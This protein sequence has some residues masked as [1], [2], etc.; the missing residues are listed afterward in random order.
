MKMNIKPLLLLSAVIACFSIKAAE[1][2]K[3]F[4]SINP[5]GGITWTND[6]HVHADHV[7]MAG[8]KMAVVLHYG[9]NGTGR[10]TCERHLVFPMLRT[11]PNDT[12][13]S[14]IRYINWDPLESVL[15]GQSRLI[16]RKEQVESI[17][18]NGLMTVQSKWGNIGVRRTLS[19]S[20]TLPAL[21]EQYELTNLSDRPVTIS[22]EP[23]EHRLT[24]DAKK[25]VDGTYVVESRLYDTGTFQLKPKESKIF[26][27]VISARRER[28]QSLLCNVT[29]E[30]AA[31]KELVARWQENLILESPDKVLDR[32]FAFSKIRACE[33]IYETK[34]G[35]MHGPGGERYYAA[36]WANDQA[37]YANPFFPFIGDPY[38][39]ASAMNS[40]NMFA[41]WMNDEWKAIPSSIIAEGTDYWN[42]AGD[43]G[44][45]AMIAYG[46]SRYAL[47]RGNRQE[48]QHLWPL[49]QWTLEYCHRQLNEAGVVCSDKDELEGR[50]PSGNANLCTSSLYYDALLSAAYLAR[51]LKQ[52]SSVVKSYE[53]Q[54]RE[55][56]AAM[57]KFFH[58][59]VEGFDTYRYYE[60]NNV[61][62]SWICIPLTVGI[63][64]RAKGTIDALYSPRLWTK[65]GMLTQAGS[66][67]FWDRS[68]LYALR[69]ALMAGDTERTLGF[70]QYYS[71]TRLLGNHVP[72]AIEAW[73]EGNQRHLSA[74]SALY[75]R[76]ITEGLFGIRPTGLH[77]FTVSPRLP[78]DWPEMSLKHIRICG[79]DFDLRVYRNKNQQVRVQLIKERKI[80][81]E[82]GC[83]ASFR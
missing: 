57:D 63:F 48:A 6:G 43:R 82:A 3:P 54:A 39:N 27:A 19:P 51:D 60:G 18:L 83:P 15:I 58:A 78:K 31:R 49:I 13:G 62:R 9:I 21:V 5:E 45:A 53:K 25:G 59:E 35:P 55:L 32:M 47:A 4:W 16:D 66:E 28:E 34:N 52:P 38:A 42:G 12:H 56:R 10:F 81:K 20:T 24:S 50:F 36:I 65:D 64:E 26:S 29:A 69:G 23:T 2:E 79:D 17:S 68:T 41:A 46:A 76:I 75:A 70:L 7:E 44:D 8:K 37:E 77:S 1:M 11:I 67:T 80:I 40:W 72:Y 33:S 74:E 73:P 22:I 14:F 71:N 61:L 30:I